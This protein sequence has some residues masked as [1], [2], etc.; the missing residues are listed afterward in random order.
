M[1]DKAFYQRR[2]REELSRAVSEH[3]PKLKQL[4]TVW[5]GL[6]AE[7]LN[8]LGNLMDLAA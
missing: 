4:H 1:D 2:L 5:A 7:R 8:R 6:Y 3:D